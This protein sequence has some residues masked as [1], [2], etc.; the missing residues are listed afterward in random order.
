MPLT[1]ILCVNPLTESSFFHY[2]QLLTRS[3][4]FPVGMD[5]KTAE[6]MMGGNAIWR[7]SINF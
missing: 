5:L 2:P 3:S 7:K 6:V 1:Y 4:S